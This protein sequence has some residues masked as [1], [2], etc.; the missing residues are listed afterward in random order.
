MLFIANKAWN[1]VPPDWWSPPSRTFPGVLNVESAVQI[2]RV[3]VNAELRGHAAGQT[4]AQLKILE[5]L[6]L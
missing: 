3:C 1:S 4:A 6:G 2:L 5:A